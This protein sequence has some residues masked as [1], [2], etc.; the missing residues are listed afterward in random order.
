VPAVLSR[1]GIRAAIAL[2]LAASAGGPSLA[3]GA[4]R[5]RMS[6]RLSPDQLGATSALSFGLEILATGGEIPSPVRSIGVHFPA[7]L[8]LSTSGLGL[9]TCSLAT[10]ETRGPAA[11]PANSQMGSGS[12]LARFDLGAETFEESAR[13]ALVA[14]PS[15][16]GYTRPLIA[17]LGETPV[18]TEIVMS[19]VLEAGALQIAV[20]L[21]P[22]LP[23][24]PDVALVAVR[25]SL[26]G[27][28]SYYET[29][30]GRRLAYRP[31]GIALPRHCPRGGFR[32]SAELTF[33]DGS[34]ADAASTVACPR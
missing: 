14:G 31:R 28:L 12:A 3:A 26:G 17:A 2:T 33:L 5:A 24:G 16:D 15:A 13:L 4:Q 20:P 29:V 6:A 30:R 22:G 27:D 1:A 21:V 8:G 18:A 7:G 9:A 23:E 19:S 10:L 25:V 11:C 32:F 34:T